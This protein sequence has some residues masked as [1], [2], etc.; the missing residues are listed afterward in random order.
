MPTCPI[1]AKFRIQRQRTHVKRRHQQR[2]DLQPDLAVPRKVLNSGPG[3]LGNRESTPSRPRPLLGR[4]PLRAHVG[5]LPRNLAAMTNAAIS[6]VRY[7]GWFRYLP[8]AHRYYA[9]RQQAALRA[10]LHPLRA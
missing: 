10:V 7:Q 8:Q 1:A 6:I 9:H 4:R 3:S 5:H 2:G